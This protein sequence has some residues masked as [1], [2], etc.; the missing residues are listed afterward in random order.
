MRWL[1][2]SGIMHI[3]YYPD[4]FIEGFPNIAELRRGISLA[5]YPVEVPK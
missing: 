3:A 2:A 4:D 5:Q 1:Q